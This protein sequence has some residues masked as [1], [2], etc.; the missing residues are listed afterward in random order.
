MTRKLRRS[1]A[2][3]GIPN[4]IVTDNGP[5]IHSNGF[6]EFMNEFGIN[7]QF[8]TP[9]WPQGNAEVERFVKTLQKMLIIATMQHMDLETC[10]VNFLF[11]YR[12][13]PHCTTKV[14]PAELL[15]NRPFNGKIPCM[16]S[17]V[18]DKHELARD[19][20][21]KAKLYNKEYADSNRKIS[22]T[23]IEIGNMV[24]MKQKRHNKL[25]SNFNPHPCTVI[26]TNKPD[27]T[28]RT[29]D[30]KVFQRNCSLF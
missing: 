4:T 20:E 26:E 10:L 28:V 16:E 7:H 30:G 6:K 21:Y 12:S 24:L 1:F 11:Q 27:V 15:Y 23:V 17:K 2:T 9:Y 19:N 13:T 5:P 22:N 18:I 25:M 29:H 3:H 14:P 8:S